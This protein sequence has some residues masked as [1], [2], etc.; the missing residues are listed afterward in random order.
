MK[1]IKVYNLDTDV[2]VVLVGAFYEL[3]RT[4]PLADVW[5]VFAMDRN[6]RFYSIN[7]ICTN[8]REPKSRALPV[9]YALTGCD[10]TL[11]FKGKGNKLA[12]HTYE[13]ITWK[14]MYLASH[15]LSICIRDINYIHN[16]DTHII[17]YDKV[18]P[19]S[20]FNE[21]R[22]DLFYWN[23]SCIDRISPM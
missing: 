7:A 4:Q 10:T 5:V 13:E 2:E 22:K 12:W 3:T 19:L 1:S 16:T 9:F 8:F 17:M 6:Y 14:L 15:T 23:N 20:F 18:C 21:A 11:A